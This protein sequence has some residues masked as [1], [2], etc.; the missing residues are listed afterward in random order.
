VGLGNPDRGDDAIGAAVAHAVAA[1]GLPH[2]AVIEHEDPTDLIELW[3][4]SD[5]VVVIDAVRSGAVAGTLVILET[6]AGLDPLPQSARRWTGSGGTHAFGTADAVELAR[7][8]RR[9]PSRLTIVGVEAR[10]FEHGAPL[11]PEVAA[12]LPRA[13]DAVVGAVSLGTQRDP[14]C[15]EGLDHVPG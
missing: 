3:S 14:V 1:L 8:L 6:G 12:A 4:G 9:L 2:V 10:G 15:E 7:A 11:S 5:P 13:L